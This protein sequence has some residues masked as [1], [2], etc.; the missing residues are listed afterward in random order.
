MVEIGVQ[1]VDK[2]E[3]L[4]DQHHINVNDCEQLPF[5]QPQINSTVPHLYNN[6]NIIQNSIN[7][8]NNND[9]NSNS[10]H[11]NNNNSNNNNTNNINNI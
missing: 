9:N 4:S 10:M 2:L 8:V 6:E 11:N 7:N 5:I 1:W 3:L